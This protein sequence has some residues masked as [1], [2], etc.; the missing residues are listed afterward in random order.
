MSNHSMTG[1]AL[2]WSSY[3]ESLYCIPFPSLQHP[4][5]LP[6]QPESPIPE[7]PV[8]HRNPYSW[9]HTRSS[10]HLLHPYHPMDS[11]LPLSQPLTN[12]LQVPPDHHPAQNL[13]NRSPTVFLE[14]VL[15][16]LMRIPGRRRKVGQ[17][18]MLLSISRSASMLVRARRVLMLVV[19]MSC[20]DEG[21]VSNASETLL[22]RNDER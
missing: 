4:I 22:A 14:C 20:T 19:L 13:Y 9:P 7:N 10:A 21:R 3:S 8:T 11:P 1:P 5:R 17:T 18:L 6:P 16:P 15:Q 2:H 12:S